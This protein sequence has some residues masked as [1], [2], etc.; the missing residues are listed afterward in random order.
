MTEQ[1]LVAEKTKHNNASCK[2]EDGALDADE[3]S[4]AEQ[5]AEVA[6]QDA[7]VAPAMP[8]AGASGSEAA[9]S[10]LSQLVSSMQVQAS[11]PACFGLALQPSLQP[12]TLGSATAK[13]T[14]QK[15]KQ[16]K[17]SEKAKADKKSRVAATKA[18]AAKAEGDA[19]KLQ[20]AEKK[21]IT[22]VSLHDTLK[23]Y[24]LK[25][26]F[27]PIAEPLRTL[28]DRMAEM[29]KD[30]HDRALED[31]VIDPLSFDAVNEPLIFDAV[32]EPK[33]D[34]AVIEPLSFVIESR[35]KMKKAKTVMKFDLFKMIEW[36]L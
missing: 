8:S 4:Q 20:A 35:D 11:S 24:N 21:Q 9:F 7:V 36:E 5:E 1:I 23:N 33:K 34:D 3:D 27:E 2:R 12:E 13:Q 14:K 32:I 10:Q 22:L 31:A 18:A 29:M 30:A 19:L 17:S 6:P 15:L 25:D 26:L 16:T 28:R